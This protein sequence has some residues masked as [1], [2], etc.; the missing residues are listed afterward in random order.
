MSYDHTP[1]ELNP[2]CLPMRQKGYH[3]TTTEEAVLREHY[4]TQGAQRC[5]DL[6]PHRGQAAVHAKAHKLGLRAPKG[7]TTGMRFAKK[8]PQSDQVDSIITATYR[9]ITKRGDIKAL[10]IRVGRPKWWVCKR[11]AELGLT[12]ERIKPL[13]WS[14]AEMAVLEEFGACDCKTIARKLKDAGFSRSP[15]AIEVQRKRAKIDTSDP[16]SWTARDLGSLLG[17]DGA[18]VAD[19]IERRGLKGERKAW[20]PNGRFRITRRSLRAWL[21]E[22]HGYVDL[23]KVDQPWFW[24]LVLGGAA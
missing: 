22:N 1:L 16:D 19:W 11:A 15:T 8:Y 2:Q 24:G 13:P 4:P 20:G 7:T 3:W 23:R 9:S 6:L 21:Q 14:R 18:T 5:A 17:V 12:L 10:A